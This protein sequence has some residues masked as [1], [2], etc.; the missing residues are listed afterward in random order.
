MILPSSNLKHLALHK[1][2]VESIKNGEFN[3][4][5]VS[6]V[7]EAIPLLMGKPFRGEDEDSVIAKIAERIDNFENLC[8]RTELWNG[9]KLA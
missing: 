8:N 7:D 6:T 2:V 5:P 3:I 1:S 9:S 4:W